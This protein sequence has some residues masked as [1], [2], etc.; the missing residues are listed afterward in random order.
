MYKVFLGN[1]EFDDGTEENLKRRR[2]NTDF[3]N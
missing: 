3:L 2:F 1:N